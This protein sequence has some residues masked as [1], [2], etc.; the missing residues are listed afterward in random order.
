MELAGRRAVVTGASSGIGA[1]TVRALAA[2][3]C[4]VALVARREERLQ[5][6]ADEIDTAETLVIPTDV[7]D[8]EA[9][10]AM[11][12]EAVET[13]GGIDILVNN[14]GVLKP[15]PVIQADR[16][17][18]R[19]QIEV[20]LLGAMYTTHAVLPHLLDGDLGD[21]VTV[22]SMNARH[23]AEGGSAYTASKYGVNGFA[24][25]LRKELSE[26]EVRVTVILPGPVVT[27]MRDWAA[28]DGRPLEPQ[29]V[30]DAIVFAV[31]RPP[32]VELPDMPVNSTDKL[33]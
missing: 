1:G 7:T 31:S 13:F 29:D 27:E 9:I 10:D 5:Q 3:G 15:D 12:E 2:E 26:E 11:V 23:A 25:S 28:W 18:L 30:G 20:N 19:S 14:A 8:T 32:H 21:I 22:S 16:A 4:D 6:I 24:D 17:D 33:G